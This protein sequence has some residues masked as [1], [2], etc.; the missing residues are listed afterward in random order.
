MKKMGF[1]L[2]EVLITLSIIGVVAAVTI[3]SL[4][5]ANRNQVNATRLANTVAILENAFSIM[6]VQEGV[7]SL[8]D[9]N[10]WRVAENDA[11]TGQQLFAGNLGRYLKHN[12]YR[13]GDEVLADFANNN[14]SGIGGAPDQMACWRTGNAVCGSAKTSSQF[15][16]LKSGALVAIHTLASNNENEVAI[17]NAGGRLVNEAADIFIDVNGPAEGPNVWGRDN[18]CFYLGHDG[19][20]YACGSRDVDIYAGEAAFP[21]DLCD[22]SNNG[23]QGYVCTN[24]LVENG[25]KVDY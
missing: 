19:S 11:L 17:R 12:G 21:D 4:V 3:P 25:Y 13:T 2:A 8:F 22:V 7:D 15:I 14:V 9:T 16:S 18:F 6:M 10:A 23:V 5:T 1:T 24:R 20:L